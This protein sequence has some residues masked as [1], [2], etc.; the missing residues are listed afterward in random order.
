MASRFND[1]NDEMV[2]PA[3]QRNSWDDGVRGR[4]GPASWPVLIA[5][6]VL[7]IGVTGLVMWLIARVVS[8]FLQLS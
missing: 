5:V 3:K 4:P 6:F 1:R 8:N 2:R 7:G